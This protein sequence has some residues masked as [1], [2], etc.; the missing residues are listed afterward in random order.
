M[1]MFSWFRREPRIENKQGRVH[2]HSALLGFTI[3]IALIVCVAAGVPTPDIIVK[4]KPWYDI[5]A[6]SDFGAMLTAVGS[7]PAT[8][9]VLRSETISTSETPPA[10]MDLVVYAGGAFSVSAGQ[11]LDLS[12]T[13]L[14]ASSTRTILSGAGTVVPTRNAMKMEWFGTVADAVTMLGSNEA[15]LTVETPTAITTSPT[16]PSTIHLEMLGSSRFTVSTAQTLTLNGGFSAPF[17]RQLFAG[18]GRVRLSGLQDLQ[19]DWWP[20]FEK[21][22]ADISSDARTLRVRSAETISGNTTVPATVR[23][24]LDPPG[25]LNPAALTTLTLNTCVERWNATVFGGSGTVV[26]NCVSLGDRTS[27]GARFVRTYDE[28]VAAKDNSAVTEIVVD[29]PITLANLLNLGGKPLYVNPGCPISTNGNIIQNFKLLSTGAYQQFDTSGG[30]SVDL[31]KSSN[32]LPV[33]ILGARGDCV[34]NETTGLIDSGTDDTVAINA[35]LATAPA[36]KFINGK[37]YRVSNLITTKDGQKIFAEAPANSWAPANGARIVYDGEDAGDILTVGAESGSSGVATSPL[38]IENL[39]FDGQYKSRYAIYTNRTNQQSIVQRN[40][41]YHTNGAI[42]APDCYYSEFRNNRFKGNSGA[43]TAL[44][45]AFSDLHYGIFRVGGTGGANS[46]IFE[47]NGVENAYQTIDGSL[48]Q[49]LFQVDRAENFR[50]DMTTIESSHAGLGLVT[51]SNGRGNNINVTNTYIESCTVGDVSNGGVF[52]ADGSANYGARITGVH[53]YNTHAYSFLYLPTYAPTGPADYGSWRFDDVWFRYDNS[54]SYFAYDEAGTGLHNVTVERSLLPVGYSEINTVA[55]TFKWI[56]FSGEARTVANRTINTQDNRLGLKSTG[57]PR[58]RSIYLTSFVGLGLTT[59][60]NGTMTSLLDGATVPYMDL[61]LNADG[62]QLRGVPLTHNGKYY[63]LGYQ[64]FLPTENAD[65]RLWQVRLGYH[66]NLYI[67]D[68][69][70]G[71]AE[72]TSNATYSTPILNFNMA[73]DDT[74]NAATVDTTVRRPPG[75]ALGYNPNNMIIFGSTDP[76]GTVNRTYIDGDVWFTNDQ[77]V[78]G[79][80]GKVCTAG[81]NPGTWKAFGH[82]SGSTA[83]R[84]SLT[85]NDKGIGYWD[86]TLGKMIFWD[87]AAWKYA[88]GTTP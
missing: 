5:R 48:Q 36:V 68:T 80:I 43:V 2:P 14:H 86:T 35:I 84:P 11:T 66:G 23:L 27:T 82:G 57:Y 39:F 32:A 67:Q 52:Y 8:V 77:N 49:F 50:M 16:V 21:A 34:L 29:A 78:N 73:A 54:F 70:A 76:S 60:A 81:G 71:G 12:N 85:T 72:A 45:A 41:F 6:Y 38:V 19:C 55:R 56:P 20:S 79:V 28:L 17:D 64:R 31:S 63:D 15:H 33:E 22:I 9:Y 59:Q 51:L 44:S 88:D 10:T 87:G 18:D 7:T 65:T 46:V 42:Y 58:E 40:F 47:H 1:R 62:A 30:G 69:T 83:A 37:S 24:I 61:L 4:G 26:Q 3:A 74:I 53:V 75:I 13:T 25:A